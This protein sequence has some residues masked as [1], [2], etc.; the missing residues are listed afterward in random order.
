MTW[1]SAM[2]SHSIWIH[3]YVAY[4]LLLSLARGKADGDDLEH[5]NSYNSGS[6]SAE[7]C[8]RR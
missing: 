1:R 6:L 7:S 5:L 8:Q 4:F 2:A 3:I